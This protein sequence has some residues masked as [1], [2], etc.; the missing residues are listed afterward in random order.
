MNWQA[1]LFDLDGTLLDTLPDL[2]HSVNKI[3]SRLG[4]PVHPV[5]AYRY[6]VG[7]GVEFLIRRALPGGESATD[8]QVETVTEA[9]EKEYARRWVEHTRPYSGVPEMLAWLE[10]RKIPKAII[11]NKPDLFTQIMVRELL[12]GLLFEVIRGATPTTP[13]KP[14]PT[15]A[16]QIARQMGAEPSQVMLVGDSSI[17]MQTASAAG[18]YPVGVSW[19]FR[20]VGELLQNGARAILNS[21][22]DIAKLL[23]IG[24]RSDEI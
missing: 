20:S 10:R 22:I 24:A 2:A 12:P 17:D 7:D 16:L 21:P 13:K 11:S 18:M 1:V 14:D 15:V 3:L 9:M 4:H 23:D 6:F 8:E 19:G 5:D